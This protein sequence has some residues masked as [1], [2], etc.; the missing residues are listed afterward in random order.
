MIKQWEKHLIS[1][2]ATVLQ[3]LERLNGLG[4]HLTLFITDADKRLY[5]SL[6]DGDI[7]RALVRNATVADSVAS[8]MNTNYSY[9]KKNEMDFTRLRDLREKQINLVPIVDE[10]HQVYRL[11]DLE[12]VRSVIPVDAV[13]MAGGE[14][15]RLRPLTDKL[16][17]PLLPVGD[18]P[19]IEHN[20]DRLCK[21]GIENVYITLKYLGDQI[22]AYFRNGKEK[23]LSIN[24]ITEEKALGTI[25]ACSL[26]TDFKHEYVLVMNSDLLTDINFEDFF[27]EFLNSAADMAVATIPY[28]VNVPYAVLET[29]DNMVL[30]FKEKPTYTFYANAGIYLFKR[31]IISRLRYNSFFN[32]TDLMDDLI[33]EKGKILS[34]PL[35]GY[36]LDI[37]KHED[38][39]K[40]QEDIKHISI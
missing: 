36:W 40:A 1:K 9:L 33:R 5:G 14:G 16:P 31:E 29:H 22:E 39:K 8:I 21:Y 25:G 23:A 18:K 12:N 37:G 4:R 13:I 17:K 38:Y 24:F 34:Y 2:D 7:R 28:T 20:I 32:A 11:L 19:I 35:L 26:I 30:N 15:R 6:T 10:A 27:I 3:A